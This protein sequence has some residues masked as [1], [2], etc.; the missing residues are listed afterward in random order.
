MG[1]FPHKWVRYLFLSILSLLG[2]G[3]YAYLVYDV[4]Q[5]LINSTALGAAIGFGILFVV[6][7][8][9][10]FWVYRILGMIF[11]ASLKG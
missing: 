11:L 9:C 6:L 1:C 8:G 4:F 10:A 7:L 5:H 2:M 3:G